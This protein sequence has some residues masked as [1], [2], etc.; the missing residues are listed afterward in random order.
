MSGFIHITEKTPAWQHALRMAAAVGAVLGAFAWFVLGDEGLPMAPPAA[1]GSTP[2]VKA[3]PL[4]AP[5]PAVPHAAARDDTHEARLAQAA[6]RLGQPEDETADDY[7]ARNAGIDVR[8]LTLQ[9]DQTARA[10]LSEVLLAPAQ[11]GFVV[12]EVQPE[13]RYERMGLKPGDVIYTLDTPGTP[14]IDE[15]SMVALMQQSELSLEVYRQGTLKR[16]HTSLV[17]V[18]NGDVLPAP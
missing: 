1:N 3:A 7:A 16:L 13:S 10:F 2:F 5:P 9:R 6:A 15:S 8:R 11:A 12:A 14:D 17:H 18:E 4:P